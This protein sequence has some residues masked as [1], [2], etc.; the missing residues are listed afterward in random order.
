LRYETQEDQK[1][2]QKV[3]D[4]PPPVEYNSMHEQKGMINLD[5]KNDIK[6][7][8]LREELGKKNTWNKNPK[9]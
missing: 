1:E 8:L 9:T 7:Q 4:H 6:S 2:H 3:T 5:T